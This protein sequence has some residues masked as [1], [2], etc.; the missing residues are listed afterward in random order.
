M[1]SS[2]PAGKAS[3]QEEWLEQAPCVQ[4]VCSEGLSAQCDTC[5]GA[6]GFIQPR[7]QRSPQPGQHRS[8]VDYSAR[9]EVDPA[10]ESSEGL[11]GCGRPCAEE[12]RFGEELLA[13]LLLDGHDDGAAFR[14]GVQEGPIH[15]AR[16][17]AD[18]FFHASGNPT[19]SQRSVARSNSSS[20]S[21]P[22]SGWQ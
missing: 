18:A 17:P 21:S 14:V 11:E 4:P 2:L 10:E 19:I 7:L 1:A 20:A 6:H 3:S 13:L 12:T 16:E 9:D 22:L 15:S 8:E 5:L